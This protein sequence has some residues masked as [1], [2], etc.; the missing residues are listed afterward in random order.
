MARVPCCACYRNCTTS[1]LLLSPCG[2]G[3]AWEKAQQV[4]YPVISTSC[5]S[6]PNISLFPW[7]G[8][9]GGSWWLASEEIIHK[10]W[11]MCLLRWQ[12]LK[13]PVSSKEAVVFILHVLLHC[14]TLRKVSYHVV[15]CPVEMSSWRRTRG[16][17]SVKS[18]ILPNHRRPPAELSNETTTPA[19]T[20]QPC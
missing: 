15:S 10:K 9:G 2:H 14:L 19:D 20:L 7:A 3:C 18:Y 8:W 6:Y 4:S 17:L 16:K 1:L 12:T 11:W 5:A 13:E